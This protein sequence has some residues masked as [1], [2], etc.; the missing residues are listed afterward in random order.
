[1]TRLFPN[2]IRTRLWLASGIAGALLLAG[3]ASAPP[4]PTASLD[5]ARQAISNAERADASRFAAAELSD[6]RARLAA[7]DGAVLKEEM[8][9]AQRSAE[10][11]RAD[12]ELAA[13][14]S[15]ASKAKTVNDEMMRSTGALTEEM[16]RAGDKR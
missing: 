13:A 3:C 8:V 11:S 9:L 12:A 15:S 16:Q 6:A 5:A 4:A 10:Q 7:A 2:E 1:M 14:R